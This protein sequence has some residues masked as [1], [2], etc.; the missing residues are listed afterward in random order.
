MEKATNV[1]ITDITIPFLD[2]V[3]FLVKLAIAA[4]PAMIIVSMVLGAMFMVAMALFGSAAM[5]IK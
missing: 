3:I 4:I 2:I 5:I 1:R